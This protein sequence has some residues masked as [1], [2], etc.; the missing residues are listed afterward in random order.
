MGQTF[1]DGCGQPVTVAG[2]IANV[3]S[4]DERRA[5]EGTG[6][7][8]ELEDGSSHLL[9]FPCIEQLP[10]HPTADDVAALEA[11]DHDHAS[12]SESAPTSDGGSRSATDEREADADDRQP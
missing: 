11:S 10:E 5:T 8:L 9:C 2:G 3:W 6:L 4:F 1:C 7:R 12:P